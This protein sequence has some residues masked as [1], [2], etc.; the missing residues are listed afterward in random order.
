MKSTWLRTSCASAQPRPVGAVGAERVRFVDHQIRAVAAAH[1]DDLLERRHVAANRIEP[2]D[3]DQTI[4]LAGREA[5][6]LLAQALRRVVPEG[7]DLRGGVT[8][9][10]VDAGVAVAVDQDDVVHAA[11]AADERQIRLVAG[12]ENQGVPLAEPVG[13]LALEIFVQRQGAVGG[14]RTG[15]A[16]AVLEQRIARGR[17]HRR[18]ER[19]AEVVVGAE[20]Q[21]AACR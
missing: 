1:L 17:H 2:F 7:H 10:V 20:H 3:D 14:S 16:G 12:A 5:L 8:R 21:R 11:Q 19:Q 9:G 18:L 15:R 13:E 4:A 6:E